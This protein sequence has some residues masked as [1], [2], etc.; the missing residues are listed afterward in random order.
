MKIIL[1]KTAPA[2]EQLK[3]ELTAKFPEYA[4]YMRGS[5]ML[6]VKKTGVAGATI[7]VRQD[8]IICNE[9]FPTM[10][11]N[12]VF[13]LLMVLLGILIPLIIYLIA[14]FPKQKEVRNKLGTYL[15]QEYGT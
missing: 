9:N 3:G 7:M 14:I 15:T 12:L 10:A 13:V 1:K 5:N 6:M 2:L 4:F 11:G 8:K